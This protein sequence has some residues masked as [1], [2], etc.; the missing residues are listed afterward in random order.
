MTAPSPASREALPHSSARE[1]IFYRRIAPLLGVLSLVAA[2]VLWSLKKQLAGDELFTS[3]EIADPS[4]LHLMRAAEHLGGAGMP[5]FYLTMWPWAHLFGLSPLSL[6]L[7]SC[8]DVCAAFLVLFAVLRRR[9]TPRAAF[10]GAAFAFFAS[11]LVVDQNVE[12]RGYGLYLLLAVLAVA[13]VLR[14]A[15]IAQP[16]PRDLVLLALTQAGLVLGHILGLFYGGLL[17][18]ALVVVD[19]GQRRFRIG[20]Y[21]AAMA[22]WLAL[23]PWIPAILASMAVGKPHTWIAMPTLADLAIGLSG[24]L[25]GGIYFPPLRN[26]PLGLVAG[27][28]CAMVCILVLVAAAAIRLRTADPAR[29]S[30]DI[31]ALALLF[32]PILFFVVSHLASPVYVGRYLIPTA[33]GIAILAAAWFE[34]SATYSAPRTAA[35][36]ACAVLLLPV[37]SALLARPESLPVARIDQL[38]A[39]RPV[40]CDWLQDFLAMVRYHQDPAPP[41]YPLD[42]NAALSGPSSATGAYRLMANY[43][44]QGYLASEIRNTSAI[45]AQPS[46]LVLDDSQTDWFH[47]EIESNPRFSWKILAPIDA[48]RSLIEVTQKPATP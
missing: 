32:A 48:K 8:V 26:H 33:I 5:L 2:C 19:R 40:V 3:I 7:A 47:L 39:G 24:W 36:L 12:A 20:V 6:R 22:G 17:L 44:A 4:L 41:Q 45:F 18:L 9:F 13:W 37:A 16:R 38:A 11:L 31:V 23:I 28:A 15:E 30:T 14:V 10:L 27:W 46:F 42:W 21:L 35:L 34:R 1:S 25:F 29:R 43:R